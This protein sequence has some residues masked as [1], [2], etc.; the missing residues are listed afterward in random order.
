ME[1]QPELKTV[2]KRLKL[3]GILATLP[4]RWAYARQEK[5]DY[6]QF[7]GT[8]PL[9]RSRAPRAQTPGEPVA[10]CR[11]RGRMHPG[12]FR[13]VRRENSHRQDALKR[14]VRPTLHRAS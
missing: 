7:F 8:G 11:L 12:A 5:L 13:L 9:R 4:D 3:S 6:P 2:L 10:G 1:I 14:A